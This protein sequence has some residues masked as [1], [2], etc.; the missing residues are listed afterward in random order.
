MASRIKVAA[1]GLGWVALHRHLPVMDRGA[2]FDV[3]GVIDSHAG[4]AEAVA[5]ERGYRRSAKAASLDD[6]AWLDE[7]DA[8]TV[9]TAPMA[10]HALVRQAL[11]RGKH[12]LTEKPFAMTVAQGEDMVA[13]AA[14]AGRQLAIVHNFQFARSTLRLKADIAAGALGA[15]TGIDAVQFGNPGRR[16]PDWYETL[17]LGLFYDESPHLLYLMR[18]IAGPLKLADTVIIPSRRG[19]ATPARIA[20][21]F[22]AESADYP[23]QL[24][25]NFESPVSEWYLMVFGEK[26]L[27]I[28]DVFRDIYISLPNDGT[29]DT[30]RVL[31]TSMVATAQHWWQHVTSG[32]PHLLGRLFYGNDQVFARFARAI[33]GDA[34]ALEPVGPASALSVL[35]LQHAIVDRRQGA[36]P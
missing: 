19:L 24:S 18:S 7:V 25:C 9:A 20:A 15:I 14:A 36:T 6:V 31:R 34:A 1:V 16:L 2:D 28:I 32:I 10:H 22:T 8:V 11:A 35:K 13:A 4:R 27:G 30:K 3:V 12:A 29:H 5:R 21:W 17:P 33:R 23:I 26:R